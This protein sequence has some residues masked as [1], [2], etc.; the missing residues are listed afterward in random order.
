ML[1]VESVKAFKLPRALG[2]QTLIKQD[3]RPCKQQGDKRHQQ[4]FI[5][6]DREQDYAGQHH[7]ED[8][9]EHG[10]HNALPLLDDRRFVGP[11]EIRIGQIA[12]QSQYGCKKGKGDWNQVQKDNRYGIDLQTEG[13]Q[14]TSNQHGRQE[15]A[16]I[17]CHLAFEDAA[18]VNRDGF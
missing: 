5:E 3:V 2:H 11:V 1:N 9:D 13:D 18:G 16:E 10:D 17:D 15:D 12:E 4:H 14:G 8:A 6:R 7:A